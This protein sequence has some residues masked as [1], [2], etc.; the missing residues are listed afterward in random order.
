[1]NDE[2]TKTVEALQLEANQRTVDDVFRLFITPEVERR[3]AAGLA[4]KPYPFKKAQ[5]VLNVDRPVQ[6][7]LDDEVKA[8]M[9]VEVEE[10]VKGGM[11]DGQPVPWDVIKS[12]TDIRLT[13]GGQPAAPS[14]GASSGVAPDSR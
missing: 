11:K 5:V 1:M 9:S 14:M 2:V 8:I 12:I 10:E 7:R 4:P 13:D 6:V 3:Q